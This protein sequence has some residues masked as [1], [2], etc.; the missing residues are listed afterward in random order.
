MQ[1]VAIQLNHFF[2]VWQ[3]GGESVCG[4][5]LRSLRLKEMCWI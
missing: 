4:K 1:K 3:Y 2:V 5:T